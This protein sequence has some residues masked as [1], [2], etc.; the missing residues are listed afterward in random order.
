M[1]PATA[2]EVS[3]AIATQ[4]PI[5]G[6]GPVR[7]LTSAGTLRRHDQ[8]LDRFHLPFRVR[9]PGGRSALGRR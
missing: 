8:Y 9:L 4:R 2:T 7:G 6:G 5:Q 1:L 3:P